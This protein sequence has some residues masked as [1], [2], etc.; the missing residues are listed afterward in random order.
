MISFLKQRTAPT[1]IV[2]GDGFE[3]TILRTDRKKSASIKVKGCY[4][5]I[6]VPRRAPLHDIEQ[7]IIKKSRWIKKQLAHQKAAIAFLQRDYCEGDSF[8][9]RGTQLKLSLHGGA[10]ESVSINGD[11]LI[12]STSKE[13]LKKERIQTLINC[14]FKGLAKEHLTERTDRFAK[15][16]GVS[17][18]SIRVKEYKSRWG[19]CSTRGLISYNW[20]IIMAPDPVIDYIVVHELCHLIEHNHSPRFWALVGQFSPDYKALRIWLREKGLMLA[21]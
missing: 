7:L 19:S 8:F 1:T 11:R 9:Y 10:E 2:Q 13:R 14:Y 12:V 3:V 6:T 5:T 4:V 15:L 16:I 18:T 17:Y 20:R 21:V